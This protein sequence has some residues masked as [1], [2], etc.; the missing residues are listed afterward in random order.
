MKNQIGSQANIKR[1]QKK[2]HRADF[3]VQTSNIQKIT[4]QIVN[5]V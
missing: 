5:M 3:Y 1:Q 2:N 4:K